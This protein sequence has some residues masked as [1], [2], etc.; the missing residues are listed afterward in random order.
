MC[1]SSFGPGTRENAMNLDPCPRELA[2]QG[3]VNNHEIEKG[4]RAGRE[5]MEQVQTQRH[6]H[7]GGD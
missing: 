7:R 3:A 5:I 1:F 4:G 6:A 2:V